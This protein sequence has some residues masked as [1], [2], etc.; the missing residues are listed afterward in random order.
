MAFSNRVRLPVRVIKPQFPDT[1]TTFTNAVGDDITL[2]SSV[3]KTYEF[4]T[5]YIPEEW[6]E[7]IA[8][9][10][11][12]DNVTFEGEKYLGG[13][14]KNAPYEIAWLEGQP[15]YP[16]A[17]G[18]TTI[19]V[20]PFDATNS[21]CVT[22]DQL[23]Q[24]VLVDDSFPYLLNE[25]TDNTID[26]IANDSVCC[27]PVVFSI[28]SFN[29][30]YLDSATI[31]DMGNVTV[32]VKTGLVAANGINLVTYRA[33][34]ENGGFDEADIFG[35]INGTIPGCLAPTGLH[36]IA[37]TTTTVHFGWTDP[38]PIPDHYYW[39]ILSLPGL[40]ALQ[41]GTTADAEASSVT[42]TPN[43]G[44]KFRVRSQCDGPDDNISDATA[45]NWIEEDFSTPPVAGDLCGNYRVFPNSGS[46]PGTITYLG[47]DGNYHS[48]AAS[49]FTP[50]NICA[51]QTAPG[52]PVDIHST[53][54]ISLT[55]L[56]LC[57]DTPTATLS[58][59]FAHSGAFLQFGMS[60]DVA[61]DANI[62]INQVFADGFST[63]DCSGGAV[64][65]AQK[66][67]TVNIAPGGTG[68][69][70]APTSFT[71][72]WASATHYRIY[73]VLINGSPVV[74]GSVVM[75]GSYLVTM[76]IPSCN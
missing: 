70:T 54:G 76:V 5:D 46:N 58:F 43:T 30:D 4:N 3:S 67:S 32:H 11:N 50:V 1:R 65:S 73:N 71:G 10:L 21:N 34:C 27:Y 55:Y 12:H 41:S 15:N 18:K 22:C 61:I 69:G 13:I 19:K 64:A 66:N 25:D 75:I 36:I 68:A 23:S 53:F 60:L 33:T 8:I 9:L 31:D 6:H 47:C 49:L 42:L 48:V 37:V 24:I 62:A 20:T 63:V 51:L 57:G 35:N 39:Q 28:T 44:Y 38:S 17:T 2:A 16:L 40:I 52:S 56:G 29:S 45:S 7:K 72:V 74:N 59:S 14:S 26:A